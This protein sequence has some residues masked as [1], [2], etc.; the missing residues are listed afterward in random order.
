MLPH[1]ELRSGAIKQVL[2]NEDDPAVRHRA[3]QGIAHLVRGVAGTEAPVERLTELW[4]SYVEP[5]RKVA[6]SCSPEVPLAVRA[7][8]DLAAMRQQIPLE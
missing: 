4:E 2:D 8:A 5:L 7:L 6:A 3:V 1:E